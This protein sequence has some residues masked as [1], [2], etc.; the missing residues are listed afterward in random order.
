MKI[1][2]VCAV[3]AL[4]SAS[5]DHATNVNSA[6]ENA[7]KRYRPEEYA[8]L[9]KRGDGDAEM[10]DRKQNFRESLQTVEACNDDKST[11]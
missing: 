6:F 10:Q 3:V 9:L 2:F 1:L 4:A 8:R 5:V 7:L 11:G